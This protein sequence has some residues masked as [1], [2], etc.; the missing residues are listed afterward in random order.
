MNVCDRYLESISS[1][2]LPSHHDTVQAMIIG[3][4][5]RIEVH[6]PPDRYRTNSTGHNVWWSKGMNG[7]D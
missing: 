6:R 4:E 1:H 3:A 5:S 2:S 7:V